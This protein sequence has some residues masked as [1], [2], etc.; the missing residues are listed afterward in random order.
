MHSVQNPN[1]LTENKHI[2]IIEIVNL[3][4]WCSHLVGEGCRIARQLEQRVASVVHKQAIQRAMLEL[5]RN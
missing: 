2:N 3:I 4:F 5:K 1:K